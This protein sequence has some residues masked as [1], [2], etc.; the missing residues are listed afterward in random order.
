MAEYPKSVPS[1]ENHAGFSLT[2]SKLQVVEVNFKDNNYML[3]N[4]DE[5]YFNEKLNLQNDKETKIIALM[6]NAFNELILK[7][8]LKSSKVS[9]SLPFESF[10]TMQVPYDN[11]LLHQDL[12]DE[13]KWELSILYP[14]ISVSDLV[15]QY[16]EIEKNILNNADTALVFA[17]QRKYLRI[18]NDFCRQNK[19]KL[20]FVDHIHI[21]SEKALSVTNNLVDKGIA[22]SIYLNYNYFSVIFSVKGRPVFHNAA[23]YEDAAEIPSLIM[24]Q[25]DSNKIIKIDRNLINA[26]FITGEDISGTFASALS[27]LM[28]VD[29]IRFNPFDKVRPVPQLL[30]NKFFLEKNNSFSPAA[31]IAYRIG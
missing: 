27:E 22:L 3:E 1:G 30:N 18:L 20:K 23:S 8:P 13:F 26:G 4:V 11:T 24:D 25:I 16:H 15:I 28:N 9:F 17:V 2:N 5:V 31:G 29:L 12:L 14:Y 6:Q 7:K 10:L 21:T 19:L